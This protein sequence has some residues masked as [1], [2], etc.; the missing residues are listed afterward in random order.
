MRNTA[1]DRLDYDLSG[2]MSA[3][4]LSPQGGVRTIKRDFVMFWKTAKSLRISAKAIKKI[5]DMASTCNEVCES[6][7]CMEALYESVKRTRDLSVELVQT[8]E[9][10][11]YI[12]K[13]IILRMWRNSLDEWDNLAEDCLLASDYEIRDLIGKIATSA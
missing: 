3:L 7:K 10:T 13:R 9:K 2:I 4:S 1:C 11:D 12:W 6:G 8:L 5:R